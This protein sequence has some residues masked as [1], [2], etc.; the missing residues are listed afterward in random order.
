M[1]C[2]LHLHKKGLELYRMSLTANKGLSWKPSC[3]KV[4]ASN[5]L[6]AGRKSGFRV[7]GTCVE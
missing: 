2:M 1:Y 3:G 5:R 6:E 4:K 7:L